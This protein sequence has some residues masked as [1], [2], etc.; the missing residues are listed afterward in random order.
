[1]SS[2]S[3]ASGYAAG[4]APRFDRLR[5][6]RLVMRRWRDEDRDPYAAMNADP[7]VMRYFP[8]TMDRA[9]SD[10]SVDCIEGLFDTQGFGW[11][12]LEVAD[13]A[14]FIGFTGLKPMPDGVPGAGGMEVGWRLARHAWH[15]G[16]ATEAAAAAVDVGFEGAGL[17][18]IWSMTAV[19]NLPSQAVMQRLEMTPYAHFD[20]PKI[21]VGHPLRPH[22]VYRLPRPGQ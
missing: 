5:T 11:W 2:S 18:E 21:D 4:V 9:A 16:Y 14:E 15:H 13:T 20:H 1:V 3:G 19:L 22:V 12:A 10:A 17:D 6:A 7:E 8:A